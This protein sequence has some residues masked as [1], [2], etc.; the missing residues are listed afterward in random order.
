M[1]RHTLD[2]FAIFR[3]FHQ[4]VLKIIRERESEIASIKVDSELDIR[5]VHV[6]NNA[7]DRNVSNCFL[8]ENIFNRVGRHGCVQSGQ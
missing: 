7:F 2:N 6:D 5:L 4:N 1:P 3:V 8:E